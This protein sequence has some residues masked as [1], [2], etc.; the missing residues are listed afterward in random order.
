MTSFEYSNDLIGN[1]ISVV[2]EDGGN[3]KEESGKKREHG[4]KTGAT[5]Q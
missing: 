3:V 2:Y 4:R 5:T 1:R